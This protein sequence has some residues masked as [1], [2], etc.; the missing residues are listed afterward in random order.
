MH[1]I[2]IRCKAEHIFFENPPKNPNWSKRFESRV[3]ITVLITIKY[4]IDDL[5]CFVKTI[6]TT[7]YHTLSKNVYMNKIKN[8]QHAFLI[9][10]KKETSSM[11]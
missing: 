1:E 9:L 2:K 6:W 5:I 10:R 8:K 3:K 11:I 4:K 7:L